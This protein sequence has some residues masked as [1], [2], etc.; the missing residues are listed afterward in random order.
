MIRS[1]HLARYHTSSEWRVRAL[2]AHEALL[3]TA[4][5]VRHC[6]NPFATTTT[7]T[8]KKKKKLTTSSPKWFAPEKGCS[9]YGV[10]EA[11]PVRSVPESRF[12]FCKKT[13]KPLLY[14]AVVV[15]S[16]LTQRGRDSGADRR[17]RC[18]WRAEDK[19]Q[20]RVPQRGQAQWRTDQSW[21]RSSDGH[22]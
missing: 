11:V 12:V 16:W 6:F 18:R 22:E 7:T 21:D 19:R 10:Q 3:L 13:P 8:R 4:S 14:S 9:S 17:G 15:R 20:P 2:L 5:C 1:R